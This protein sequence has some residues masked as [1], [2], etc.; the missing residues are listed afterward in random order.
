[1]N[2]A[3]RL[4]NRIREFIH[5]YEQEPTPVAQEMAEQYAE[6]C[7]GLNN[8]LAKCSEFL[9]KGMRSEAVQEA[10]E[11]PSV[12]DLA[13][14]LTFEELK[15]WRNLCLDL[16]MTPP[17][18]LQTE[19]LEKLEAECSTEEFLEPLLQEFR[20]LVHKGTVDD[21]IDVLRRIREYD[22]DNTV[23][24]E[25]IEPLEQQQL[26]AL[27][28]KA[29]AALQNKDVQALRDL[30][31]QLSDPGRIVPAPEELMTKVE[32][33]LAKEREKTAFEEGE[34][35]SLELAKAAEEQDYDAGATLLQA[36]DRLVRYQDFHPA[37][38]M[39]QRVEDCRQ[40]FD[41]ESEKATKRKSYEEALLRVRD[42]LSKRTPDLTVL[43]QYWQH[44]QSFGHA[45]PGD[46]AA[47]VT[48]QIDVLQR[49]KQRVRIFKAAIILLAV[50]AVAG[51]AVFGVLTYR[52]R[53]EIQQVHQR[54]SNLWEDERYED[55]KRYINSLR[56]VRPELYRSASVQDYS[57][58]A[59]D[60]LDER[61]QRET[62]RQEALDRLAAIRGGG[63]EASHA[64]IIALLDKAERLAGGADEKQRIEEWR[65]GWRKWQDDKQAEID[66]EFSEIMTQ[67]TSHIE[68]FKNRVE[69]NA[70]RVNERMLARLQELVRQGRKLYPQVTPDEREGWQALAAQLE[71]LQ[72]KAADVKQARA[73]IEARRENTIKN[74]ARNA[75]NLDRYED[76][77]KEFVD[78]FPAAPESKAFRRVLDQVPLY[79]DAAV[80]ATREVGGLPSNEQEL[81]QC[82]QLIDALP[83]DTTSVWYKDLLACRNYG[84]QALSVHRQLEEIRQWPLFNLKYVRVRKKGAEEWDVLY[85]PDRFYSREETDDD[86][87][88]FKVYWSK[89]YTTSPDVYKLRLEHINLTDREYDIDLK[90]EES[91]NLVPSA[92]YAR[93]LLAMAPQEE[94]IDIFLLKQIRR[95]AADDAMQLVPK[96]KLVAKLTN[97]VLN[98]TPGNSAALTALADELRGLPDTAVWINQ[99]HQR[100][101]TLQ[102]SLEAAFAKMPDVDRVIDTI[103][104]NKW[105]LT[106][107]LNRGVRPVGVMQRTEAGELQPALFVDQRPNVIWIA[108]P[109]GVARDTN[110]FYQIYTS[111]RKGGFEPVPGTSDRLFLGQILF[112][113]RDGLD[114]ASF[115]EK[116]P[117]ERTGLNIT[118]PHAWPLN[119]RRTE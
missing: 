106:A 9:E 53:M 28:A 41:E 66:R 1:M 116:A 71:T 80:L 72:Q 69:R 56:D 94:G 13:D 47:A 109:A 70:D 23:W 114:T 32:S 39:L 12:F 4:V 99:E 108:V 38:E 24:Q 93:E 87:N 111:D 40:W 3:Q 97:M 49:R 74:V 118:W 67:L 43:Q 19:T 37:P 54:L 58:R 15:N 8:R 2:P 89:V 6:Q 86:G 63:Y 17:P 84:T 73:A 100:V 30:Y 115:L 105:F 119:S 46:L 117:V 79:R 113:P 31:D 20:R 62:E 76:I 75:R 68:T 95:V 91:Q 92:K 52:E 7:R 5:S 60:I 103:R 42:E 16:G 57:R 29:D 98:M 59:S 78:T 83:A 101:Q 10:M 36:W 11:T 51:G 110:A 50:L 33:V 25:N 104:F 21:R 65:A 34:R 14:I 18:E 102:A 81:E 96:A 82:G 22:A 35:L 77:L 45:V 55:L 88:A 61:E 64:E 27:E 112:A 85:Y 44:L 90:P 48:Q 26:E 107:M